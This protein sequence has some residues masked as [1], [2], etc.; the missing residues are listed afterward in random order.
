MKE[1]TQQNL[2]IAAFIIIGLTIVVALSGCTALQ[3]AMGF[4]EEFIENE[5]EEAAAKTVW[6]GLKRLIKNNPVQVAVIAYVLGL[7]SENTR[8]RFWN[9]I[10]RGRNDSSA[11]RHIENH[12]E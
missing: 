3:Q 8:S 4:G 9:V 7:G 5:M 6:V 10:T 12:G 2:I 11:S 1:T